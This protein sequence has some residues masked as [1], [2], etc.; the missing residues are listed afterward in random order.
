MGEKEWE[1]ADVFDVFG[2]RLARQILVLASERRVSADDLAEQL[3]VSAP[4]V[5]R[6]VNALSEYDLLAERQQLDV[7]GNHYQTFETAMK[8]VTLEI[9]DGGYTVDLQLRRRLADRFESFWSALEETSP[10]GRPEPHDRS[11]ADP[12]GGGTPHG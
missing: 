1:P 2:D 11:D 4:T 3:D 6:R 8:R 10:Q 9:E 5:Y 7:D 12:T